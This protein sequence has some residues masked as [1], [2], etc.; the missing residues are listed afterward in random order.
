MW[1]L[2]TALESWGDLPSG[3]LVLVRM[4][5]STAVAYANYGAGRVAHLALLA[6]S[7]K[8]LEAPRGCAVVARHIP[9]WRNAV[10]DAL[11]RF[12]VRA[13]GLGPFPHRELRPRYRQEVVECC[14]AVDFDMLARDDS[15]NAWG[16]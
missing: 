14:G 5:D 12:T 3:K 6:R 8:E 7:F 4:D 9:G 13:R 10:A 11:S 15:S 1:V 16:P 2:K